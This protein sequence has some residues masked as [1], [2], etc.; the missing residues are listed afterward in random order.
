MKAKTLL[1]ATNYEG[2][3]PKNLRSGDRKVFE[4]CRQY[5]VP[6]IRRYAI[7]GALVNQQ[8]IV[9]KGHRQLIAFLPSNDEGPTHLLNWKGKLGFLMK[10]RKNLSV[11]SYMLVHS[12]FSH[13]YYHWL[14]ESLPKLYL[15][16]DYISEVTVLLP[17]HYNEDF[18]QQSLAIFSVSKTVSI[19]EKYNYHVKSLIGATQLKQAH[20]NPQLLKGFVEFLK[21]RVSLDF[22][23]ADRIYVSRY[24][25]KT[26]HVKNES[27]LKPILNLHNI[28][29][30]YLEDYSFDQQISIFHN[31]QLVIGAHGAG[32]ANMIFMKKES[33]ILELRPFDG[34]T[35]YFFY[36]LANA[37]SHHYYYQFGSS[38]SAKKDFSADFR[39]DEGE[40][41]DNIKKIL[42]GAD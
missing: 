39:V 24:Q 21:E 40:F 13:T 17:E 18:H 26:R 30:V 12:P 4:K 6:E 41:G 37:C 5:T 20:H 27:H 28:K 8:S 2:D 32:L 14:L 3:W 38:E 22:K 25:A 35:N 11:G 10:P 42:T 23:V 29:V 9:F 33:S 34:G 36:A 31:S 19:Q 15:L 1:E 16:R 7:E